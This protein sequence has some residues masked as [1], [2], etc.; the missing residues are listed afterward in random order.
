MAKFKLEV[1]LA[2]SDMLPEGGGVNSMGLRDILQGIGDQLVLG[3]FEGKIRDAN[4]NTRGSFY[5]DDPASIPWIGAEITSFAVPY[6]ND[7]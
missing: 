3:N 4:G 5:I 1:D 7:R 2:G 6:E